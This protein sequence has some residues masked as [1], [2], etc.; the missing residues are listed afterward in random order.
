MEQDLYQLLRELNA[1]IT[2]VIVSHDL[3]FVS[4]MVK[5]VICVKRTVSYHPASAVTGEI[6]NSMYGSAMHLVAHDHDCGLESPKP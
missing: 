6:I 4:Q 3:G 1:S 5:T 2:V